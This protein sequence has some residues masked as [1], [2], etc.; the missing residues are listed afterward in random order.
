MI[1]NIE[2]TQ[3]NIRPSDIIEAKVMQMAVLG[4]KKSEIAK[5][6]NMSEAN[7]NR[8]I[9]SHKG[10]VTMQ[11]ALENI[12]NEI[13]HKLPSIIESALSELEKIMLTSMLTKHRLDAIKIAIGIAS[14]L[15]RMTNE[16]ENAV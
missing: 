14:K 8:I 13:A 1:E 4:T 7:V 11:S 5:Q 3:K 9:Y 2:K 16:Q 6:F 15:D 10:Q 12:Q